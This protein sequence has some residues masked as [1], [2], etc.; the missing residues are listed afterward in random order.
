MAKAI[1]SVVHELDPEQPVADVKTLEE[2]RS[3]SMAPI[4]LTATLLALFAVLAFAIT[5]IGISGVVA[6]SVTERTQEIGIRSALGAGRREV[7]ELILRQGLTLVAIGLVIG[8]AFS[9]AFTRILSSVLFG[10]EPNDPLTFVMVGLVL[11]AVVSV[12]C[13]MPARRAM[14]IDPIIALRS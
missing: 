12:A 6:F 2:V 14:S 13:L 1:R 10:V 4:R 8:V 9:L 11:A 5:V 7:L 3:V